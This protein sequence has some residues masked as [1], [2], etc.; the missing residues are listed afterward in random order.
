MLRVA[1]NTQSKGSKATNFGI[2]AWVTYG[3]LGG[4]GHWTWGA[5]GAL[6]IA[7]AI[8]AH[9]YSRGAVK[10][11]DCVT[12]GYFAIVLVTTIAFGPWLFKTCNIF[13]SWGAFALV[14][15]VAL[16]RGFPFTIQ[17]AREKAPAE[18]WDH[19]IFLRLNVILT[20]VFGAMFSINTVLGAT[21]LMTGHLLLLGL[22]LP[23]SLLIAAIGFSNV[24]PNKYFERVAPHWVAAQA[25]Q[26]VG[27][28]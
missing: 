14:T 16:Y 24:Y 22:V 4:A 11:L 27:R 5:L 20:V 12:A 13:L 28:E 17:Y 7:L 21:A 19:P 26:A 18:I 10:L 15:W 2:V 1:E 25:A 6:V 23:L 9:E 3:T 8:V